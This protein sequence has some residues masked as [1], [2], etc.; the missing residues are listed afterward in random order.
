M[1]TNPAFSAMFGHQPGVIGQPVTVLNDG[2]AE[3]SAG[4]ARDYRAIAGTAIG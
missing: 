1:F 3:E 2:S 4:V